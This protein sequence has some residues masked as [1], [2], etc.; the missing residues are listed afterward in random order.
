MDRKIGFWLSLAAFQ[1]VFGLAVFAIT[2]AYYQ[3]A[4]AAET[5]AGAAMPPGHPPVTGSATGLDPNAVAAVLSTFP[6]SNDPVEIS[7]QADEYFANEQYELAAAQY[8]RLLDFDPGRA[9][10]YNNLGLTLHYLG[11]SDEALR[12]LDEGIALGTSNQRIWLT[13][14]FVNSQTGNVD[15]ARSAFNKVIEMDATSGIAES[16]FKMLESLPGG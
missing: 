2:R 16:A 8:R 13:Y 12:V 5:K 11:R 10:T 15:A 3:A 6:E 7:R 4:P 9:E 1:I 14:G